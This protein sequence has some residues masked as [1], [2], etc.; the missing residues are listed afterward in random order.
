MKFF[1]FDLDNTLYPEEAGVHK[2]CSQRIKLY[3]RR[4]GMTEEESE[5]LPAQYYQDYGLAIRGLLKHHS[6]DPRDYDDFVDGGL[7]LEQ[8]LCPNPSLAATIS[9]LEGKKWVFTNAGIHHAQRT[10]RVLGLEGVFDGIV[11]ADYAD[12][13]FVCK[14]EVEAFERAM[15][16]AGVRVGSD[17]CVFVDDL[18]MN[19]EAAKALGWTTV[20]V[21]GARAKEEVSCASADFVVGLVDEIK[22]LF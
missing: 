11:W 2:I 6:V 1:F 16:V 15:K 12:P 17:E 3:L 10:L 5:T 8:L 19:V 13:G 9:A 14:P 18:E 7:P 20:L 4:M 21:R 22:G